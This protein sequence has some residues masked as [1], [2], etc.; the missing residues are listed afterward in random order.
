MLKWLYKPIKKISV[1]ASQPDHSELNVIDKIL[2]INNLDSFPVDPVTG[3]YL[4]TLNTTSMGKLMDLMIRQQDIQNYHVSGISLY[5]YF[6]NIDIQ[7]S[8]CF[9]R[10]SEFVKAGNRIPLKLQDDLNT[11]YNAF[12]YLQSL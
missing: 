7:P 12:L 5:S 6:K 3:R 11:L 9:R 1:P 8:E 10:L 4:V 2:K